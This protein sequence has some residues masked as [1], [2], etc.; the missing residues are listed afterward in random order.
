MRVIVSAASTALIAV[1]FAALPGAGCSGEPEYD[2]VVRG[3]T[4]Y[5]GSGNPGFTG[6]VAID[7]DRIAYVGPEAPGDARREIDA[8]GRAVAPGFINMLSWSNE[9]LL[10]DGREQGELR[11]GVTLEVMGEG[12]S[13]GPLT[14]AMKDE[15]IAQQ[16]DLKY[17]IEWTTLGEYLETLER[18]GISLNVASHIGAATARTNLLASADVDPT[19]E[20]LEAMQEVVRRAMEEGALGVG[21]S[22]IYVPGTFAG[23]DELVALAATAGR[24]GGI[25]ATHMRSEGGQ[26]LEA[27]DETI[28]ISRRSG[29]P[30]EIWH[31]KAA[32]RKNWPK[33][34]TAIA[35]I[36][37]ARREG[38][39]I[40]TDMYAYPAAST[41]LDAAMPPWVQEGGNAAWYARLRDPV[42]RT[43]VA[44]EM[45]QEDA[46]WNNTLREAGGADNVLIASL[47]N[48]VLKPLI[49]KTLAAI[50][51]E[52][53]VSA[54]EAAMG[55]VAEDESRV[56]SIYFLM[57]EDEVRR[58]VAL[59]YMSFGSD[60]TAVSAEGVF[61]KSNLH[62]RGYGNFAR[63][64]ARY[65]REEQVIT[66][67]DAVRRMTAHPASVL[68][69]RDRGRLQAGYHADIVVFDPAAIQDHATYVEP[70][71]YATGVSHV[72]V[73]GVLALQDGEPT[74]ARPGRFVRGR[75]WT[76]WDGGGCR[77]S[78]RDW[79]WP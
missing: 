32:G 57:S 1:L 45:R 21:S 68:G 59:P 12:E 65:V 41:G 39:R 17:E 2:L 29:T 58:K 6:D 11:Q 49:G 46:G 67:E 62:P 38:L 31:L 43:R 44:T 28:E 26:L 23:T 64:L 24:C 48:P 72:I 27:I 54:E 16:G 14:P 20:Q 74:E 78:A 36:E 25:Y 9:S 60:G 50:A 77:E 19:P 10:I 51:A 75:G 5:D 7:G 42:I 52:R 3:G 4:I 33:F 76:G 55:L 71:Q 30:A 37:A 79:D 13:M 66:L 70:H 56:G 22:L 69:L 53:G 15:L 61:L 34:E 63:V 18:K 40:T 73:N 8:R 47:R 35:R